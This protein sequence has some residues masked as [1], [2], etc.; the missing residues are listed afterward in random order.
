MDVKESQP[1][2]GMPLILLGVSLQR[3]YMYNVNSITQ[4]VH[5]THLSF[6]CSASLSSVGKMVAD[7]DKEQNE[8]CCINPARSPQGSHHCWYDKLRFML[9]TRKTNF[10]NVLCA[11]SIAR[12]RCYGGTPAARKLIAGVWTRRATRKASAGRFGVYCVSGTKVKVR[13]KSQETNRAFKLC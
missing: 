10:H 9:G 4:S 8:T 12:L 3:F 7:Q 11:L 2:S 1:Q 13:E 5:I 6:Q